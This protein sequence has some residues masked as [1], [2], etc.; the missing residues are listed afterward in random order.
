MH[1]AHLMAGLIR[2]ILEVSHA[3]GAKRVT[4]VSVCLGALSHI[5]PEHFVEHFKRVSA[6]TPAEGARLDVS[7]SG[8]VDDARAQDIVLQSIEVEA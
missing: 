4:G 8:D 3:E 7:V 6:S 2:Q 1:D 5:S